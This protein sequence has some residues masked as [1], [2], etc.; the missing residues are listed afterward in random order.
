MA[1]TAPVALCLAVPTGCASTAPRS[2]AP[3]I[4]PIDNASRSAIEELLDRQVQAWNA[5]DIDEFM[6]GYWRSDDLTF[7]SGGNVTRGWNATL[8]GYRRRYA[9]R[10]AMGRLEFRIIEMR[11]LGPARAMVLGR[12]R[13]ERDHPI[14]GLFTLIVGVVDGAWRVIYDHTSVETPPT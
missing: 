3:V 2:N 14:A 10:E 8:E 13:V 5:G 7:V 12:W 1:A 4:Q 11:S 6:D 9:S